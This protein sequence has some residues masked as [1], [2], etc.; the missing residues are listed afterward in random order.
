[1]GCEDTQRTKQKD[2][3][4]FAKIYPA[5]PLGLVEG[6]FSHP[7]RTQHEEDHH[8]NAL[9]HLRRGFEPERISEYYKP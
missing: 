9:V 6:P 1:M 3:Q 2:L 4:P 5:H 7:C 8:T